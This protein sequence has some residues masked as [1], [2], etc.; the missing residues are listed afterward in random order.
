M[1][2]SRGGGAAGLIAGSQEAGSIPWDRIRRVKIYPR[3]RAITI[4][5]SWR[6]V[7]RVYAKPEN[8]EAVAAIIRERAQ[9][10]VIKTKS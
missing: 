3:L 6:V 4:K 8:F 1:S 7:I 5:N 2:Y 10:A 9:D